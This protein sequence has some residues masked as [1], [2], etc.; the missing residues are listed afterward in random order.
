LDGPT[1]EVLATPY[2]QSLKSIGI[3]MQIR[4]VDSAEYT[5]RMRTRDFEMTY[6]AWSQS[7][8]PGNEQYE[9]FGSKS[10]NDP[11]TTNYGGIANPAIDKLIDT[12][13][14][15]PDRDTLVAA[16]KALDRVLLANHY[17]IPSYTL[18]NERIARWDRFSHPDLLPDYSI[19]FPEIWWYDQAKAE[20][21][22]AAR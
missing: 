20:N 11:N 8:S 22:G 2:Q 13:V 1:I 5:N 3:D 18:R 21:T 17:V 4:S 19:G 7:L 6:Q 10:A 9:F 12:L 16:T 14:H 15:A